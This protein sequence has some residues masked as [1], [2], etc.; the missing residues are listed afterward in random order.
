MLTLP[1]K[2]DPLGVLSSTLLVV[3]Q[4]RSVSINF[5]S[6]ELLAQ[7]IAR[8]HFTPVGWDNQLHWSGGADETAN[9]ILVLDALNF[10]FWGEPRWIVSHDG[11]RY[12]GYWA[13]AAA[14][15]RA[16][17]QGLPLIDAGFLAS[18]DEPT[19]GKILA[20][21]HTIPLL[22]QRVENLR[23][24][25]RVLLNHHDGQFSHLI[26]QA[27]GSAINLVQRVVSEFPSFNDITTYQGHEVRFYKRAQ[28]LA[29]DLAGSFGGRGLG[30]FKDLH[31]LTAFADYKV[32][33]VLNQLNV[34]EYDDTLLRV[35]NGQIEITAGDPLEIEIRAATIWA[36][37]SLRQAL[38]RLGMSLASF[39]LD[40]MLWQVGQDLQG[41]VRPYHHTRTIYY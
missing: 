17:Q 18:I 7:K 24:V 8:N 26:R 32:P 28:I 37:E 30:F 14:L 19:L 4:A 13:L 39:E 41:N 38:E 27:A 21:E 9:F 6:V 29:S 10:C 22:S 16:M 25:G 3:E 31:Q 1:D 23:E 5:Q 20:G 12:N 36:V 35:L 33:Q 34:L 40:W 15:T 2:P 11:Q